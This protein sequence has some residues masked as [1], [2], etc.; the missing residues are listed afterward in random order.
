MQQEKHHF[1]NAE[2]ADI[3][4][5]VSNI[6]VST[7]AP[8]DYGTGVDYTSVEVH[9][10]KYIADNPGI[11]VTEIARDYGR[12]KGAISQILKK[13]E[14][15]GLIT[16]E[17][18]PR[19]DNKTPL[20]VTELGKVLDD[21]H[22]DYDERRFGESMNPVRENFT[23]EEIDTTFTVLQAWLRV[24]RE[25]EQKRILLKKQLSLSASK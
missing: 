4:H 23:Q 22:R 12:S 8:H 16:R 24:R 9:L 14:E 2:A 11:T 15:K 19:S 21:A 3:I 25:V 17:C 1:T 18:T 20:Y 6:Y 13:V 5:Q 10:V 7:K